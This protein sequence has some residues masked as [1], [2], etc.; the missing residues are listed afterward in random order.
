MVKKELI[1]NTVTVLLTLAAVYVFFRYLWSLLLL[2][3]IALGVAYLFNRP[4]KLINRRTRLSPKVLSGIFLLVTLALIAFIIFAAVNRMVTELGE[5]ISS[6]SANSDRYVS[7]FFAF[8]D[9]LATKIPFLSAVGGDLTEVVSEAVRSMLTSLSAYIPTLIANIISVLPKVLVFSVII[10]LASYY[11][12]ADFD[13]IKDNLLSLLPES[14]RDTLNRFKNRLKETGISYLK[15]CGIML[16]ITY[17]ELLV[18]FLMLGVPYALTL[19]LVVAAVDMLPI[20]GVGTVLLPWAIWCYFT[21]DTYT[22]VGLIIIFAT[23][24]VAR[25]F[26]EPKVIGEGIGLSP[27]T[28]LAAMYI[29]FQLF[30]LTGLFFSPLAAI[31]ILH[32]LPSELSERLGLDTKRIKNGDKP[33]KKESEKNIS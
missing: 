29:G 24:T 25:R 23:V 11:F 3:L 7:E 13:R 31:L 5:L 14:F 22:A 32:A 30:G 12:C 9:S 4:I 18:G 15:A 26:I 10:I 20:L 16:V 33:P 1:K 2:F 8:I 21:G 6:L 17:F 19:S 27:I 28:T